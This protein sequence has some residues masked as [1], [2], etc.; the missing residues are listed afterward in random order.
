MDCRPGGAGDF[1]CRTSQPR[2]R[3]L[4]EIRTIAEYNSLHIAPDCCGARVLF[5]TNHPDQGLQ[6]IGVA[7]GAK[8]QLCRSFE[9]RTSGSRRPNSG[10]FRVAAIRPRRSYRRMEPFYWT[11]GKLQ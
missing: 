10:T 11:K 2:P 1:A 9:D 7:T 5:D 4:R 8:R 6:I 3:A